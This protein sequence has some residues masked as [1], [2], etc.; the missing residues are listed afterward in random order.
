MIRWLCA[1]LLVL[2]AMLL[3]TDITRAD[4]DLPPLPYADDRIHVGVATCAGSDCHGAAAPLEDSAVQQNEYL[5]WSQRDAHSNAYQLL[6]SGAGQRIAAN[7][8]LEHAHEAQQCLSCHTHFVPEDQRGRRFQAADGVGCEACHGGAGDWLGTHIAGA[9]REENLAAG[10]YPL[11]EPEMRA[12]VCL[13]CHM[14]NADKP[15]HHRL[16]GAGHPELWFEL[17]LFT[18]IQPA[19]FQATSAYRQRKHYS[20]NLRTW[21]I[22]QI[23][24]AEQYLEGLLS[25]DF[26]Q[27]GLFPELAYF[28]CAGCHNP[29]RPPRWEP[30]LA[31]QLGPGSPRLADAHLRMSAHV[32][33][34]I[35]T[36]SAERWRQLLS[37]MQ[38]LTTESLSAVKQSAQAL[39]GE[40]SAIR[41][42]LYQHA[43][44][45]N[46]AL[47]ILASVLD[48]AQTRD[49]ADP[50][51]ARQVYAAAAAIAGYLHLEHQNDISALDDA[52]GGL[53]ETLQT[54]Y[55]YEPAQFRAALD[56]V[57]SA[58][59]ALD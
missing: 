59:E 22:G 8:G 28:N 7:L 36:D 50:A 3:M 40:L 34:V 15:V 42:A 20:H 41:P 54:P 51:M 46:D 26:S 55:T 45:R 31:G 32:L 52:L 48:S 56:E 17:D 16:M 38:A 33:A 19:H 30:A 49:A 18:D 11:D 25:E 21:A 58:A 37:E 43:F 39:R 4:G 57:Q 12:R 5:I 10:L 44:S 6:L 1:N 23:L 29:M 47:A 53:F 13:S 2:T 27:Q 24:A 35:D 9:S 14:G